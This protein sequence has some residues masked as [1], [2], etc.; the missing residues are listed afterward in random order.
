MNH[1]LSPAH[2]LSARHRM[3]SSL[4]TQVKRPTLYSMKSTVSSKGQVTIPVEIRQ[5]LGLRAG[6]P[7]V[8]ERHPRGALLRKGMAG[9]HPVDRIF[10][11]LALNAPVDEIL[12]D[13][14]GP[15]LPD[16]LSKRRPS[17]PRARRR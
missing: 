17:R 16:A 3:A 10:G 14:R 4:T 11:S 8:F 12:D 9:S 13:L 7:V 2:V 5:L 15:R 1:L 6:T